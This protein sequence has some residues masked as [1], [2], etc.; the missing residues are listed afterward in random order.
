MNCSIPNALKEAI[1]D[2]EIAGLG[3]ED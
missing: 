3:N 2:E 1:D